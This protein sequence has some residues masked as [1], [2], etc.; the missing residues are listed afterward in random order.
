MNFLE[1]AAKYQNGVS[2]LMDWL[3]AG[4]V[5]VG[6][7]DAQ[8]RADICLQCPEN[9]AGWSVSE[10]VAKAIKTHVELKNNLQL[11]VD[12]EKSLHTCSICQCALRLKVHVPIE[13]IRSH[14]QPGEADKLPSYCWQKTEP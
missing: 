9:K 6:P 1:R 3:G 5:A 11:R 7:K 13:V 14:M 12:G 2:T 4:G 10:T 8:R